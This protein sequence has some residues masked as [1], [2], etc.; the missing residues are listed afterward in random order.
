MDED[1][2][3]IPLCLYNNRES[4]LITLPNRTRENDKDNL[5]CPVIEG[6]NFE[7]IFYVFNPDIKPKPG[8]FD[9][10]CVENNNNTTTNIYN[11]YDP[12]SMH[13][14]LRFLAW[15]EATPCSTPLYFWKKGG[16]L[17]ITFNENEPGEGYKLD[18]LIPLIFVLLPQN[19]TIKAEKVGKCIGK[20]GDKITFSISDRRCIP[21]PSS[22]LTLGECMV[23]LNQ[24][25]KNENNLLEY[26]EKNYGNKKEKDNMNTIYLIILIILFIVILML[27]K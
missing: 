20:F 16:K 13:N 27:I 24:K 6:M 5:V 2:F 26:L 4:S 7:S 12:F 17:K 1:K 11:A 3:I 19:S 18:E 14:C 21:D 22:K 23:D 10:F 25:L 8:Y 15:M 9:L